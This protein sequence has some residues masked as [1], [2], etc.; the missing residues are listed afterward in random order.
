MFNIQS[1]LSQFQ[2]PLITRQSLDSI[3]PYKGY[4]KTNFDSVLQ[5][6]RRKKFVTN[7][8]ILDYISVE[9]DP[10]FSRGNPINSKKLE[11]I[12]SDISVST[13]L[14]T[15]VTSKLHILRIHEF[16]P[17]NVTKILFDLN[18]I[19]DTNYNV[20]SLIRS[21]DITKQIESSLFTDLLYEFTNGKINFPELI[22]IFDNIENFMLLKDP[23]KNNGIRSVLGLGIQNLLP[24]DIMSILN[25]S[26]SYVD[27]LDEL[28]DTTQEKD[29]FNQL[30]ESKTKTYSLKKVEDIVENTNVYTNVFITIDDPLGLGLQD[31]LENEIIK[32]FQSFTNSIT[33]PELN[34]TEE[35][36]VQVRET[37]SLLG[38]KTFNDVFAGNIGL[39]SLTQSTKAVEVETY[40]TNVTSIKKVMKN[41][42]NY[43]IEQL[44]V[45][46][47]NQDPVDYL[48]NLKTNI[49]KRIEMKSRGD[50]TDNFRIIDEYLRNTIIGDNFTEE[51]LIDLNEKLTELLQDNR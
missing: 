8:K 27:M 5:H 14:V 10:N 29:L 46:P 15:I 23:I 31:K 2:N 34:L 42:S 41:I 20:L 21:G 17:A 18:S 22:T 40:N 35:Q 6:F 49:R 48:I 9:N 51:K 32:D 45:K 36:L 37:V 33:F 11:K 47:T 43:I 39:P 30:L 13:S 25:E 24:K 4:Y 7:N 28:F 50:T 1:F 26:L 16:L 44:N 38:T 12:L 3:I 19:M